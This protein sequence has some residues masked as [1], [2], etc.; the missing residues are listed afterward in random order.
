MAEVI[1][2]QLN[3]KHEVLSAG[4]NAVDKEGKSR[5]GQILKDLP[6]AENVLLSLRERGIDV[7]QNKITQLN[8]DMVTWADKIVV[9]AEPDTI[10]DYLKNSPKALYWNVPDPKGTPLEGHRAAVGQIDGLVK[11]FIKENGL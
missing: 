5:D 7:A 8:P 6:M 3:T 4:T 9:M 1:F 11:G 2:K 10:P